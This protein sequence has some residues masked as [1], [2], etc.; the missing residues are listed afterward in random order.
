MFWNKQ[1]QV[2]AKWRWGAL[3]A[4]GAAMVLNGLA[5][6]TT[7]LGGVNTAQVSDSY[8]NLFAPSGVTFAI[9]GVIY[10]LLAVFIAY[11]FGF[12]RSKKSD[13]TTKQLTEV[14]KLF[15]INIVIN[16]V[17]I[18]AWQYKVLWLSVLLMVGILVTLIQIVNILRTVELRGSEYV[19][20]RL[21]FSIYYGWITVATV[22]NVTTWLVSTGWD[23][24][25]IR[26]GGWM[27][28]ILL[29]AAAI[30]LVT[31]L[32]NRDAAYL[33]VFVWAFAGILL[34]HLST[35]GFNGMYPSTIVTLT[36]L[37]AVFLS[38]IIGKLLPLDNW[39]STRKR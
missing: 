29:V 6:S 21:P 36:I 13:L 10:P 3:A 15:T 34:K 20:M 38:V 17:W 30:G 19:Q 9:W 16:G 14:T 22:A 5:G 1:A 39:F 33:A 7:L 8:P 23:G 35:D 27:V 24:W 4:F 2:E 12:G 11:V 31:A 37:L 32:R 25:G 18:L 28:A 26:S